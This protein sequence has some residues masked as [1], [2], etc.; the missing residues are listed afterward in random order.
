[1]KIE[2]LG[3]GCKKCSNLA[4]EVES[5]ATELGVTFELTKVTDMA[6]ILGYEVM[7]TPAIVIDGKVV[8]SGVIPSAD[9]IKTLINQTG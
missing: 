7:S 5:V 9:E 3:S 1:M 6:V 2:I 4:T 8:C